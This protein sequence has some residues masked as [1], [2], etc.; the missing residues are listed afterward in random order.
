MANKKHGGTYL[1]ATPDSELVFVKG[2]G[3]AQTETE[4]KKVEKILKPKR[5][6]STDEGG[7]K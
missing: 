5:A 3:R 2:T 1:K 6:E 7:D 4:R